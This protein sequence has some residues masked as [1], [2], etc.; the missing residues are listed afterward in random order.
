MATPVPDAKHSRNWWIW[1]S[2]ALA[3]IAAALLIW[4]LSLKS[5]RDSA[6]DELASTQQQLEAAKQQPTPEPTEDENAAGG[7]IAAAGA[8]AGFKTL[9]DK[10]GATQQDLEATEQDLAEANKKV[11]QAE[12]DAADAKKKAEQADNETEKAQAE[13]DQAK[14]EQQATE[15][16]A[17]IVRDCAKSYLSAFGTL[18]ESDDP[19]AEADAVGQQLSSITDECQKALAGS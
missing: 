11:E 6:Q 17:A 15:S 12:K 3:L 4:A 8:I 2:V 16:K 1:V 5:D 9:Y 18:V 7:A 19:E 13:A 14:A 10:L